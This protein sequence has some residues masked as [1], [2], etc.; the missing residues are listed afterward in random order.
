MFYQIIAA[1]V[2]CTLLLFS[3]PGLAVR[4]EIPLTVQ[5]TQLLGVNAEARFFVTLDA[6]KDRAT[7]PTLIISWARSRLVDPRRSTVSVVI[8]GRVRQSVWLADLAQAEYTVPLTGLAGGSHVVSI[9]SSMWVDED[10]CLQR[11]RNDAWF[12]IKPSSRISWERRVSASTRMAVNSIPESWLRLA[13]GKTGIFLDHQAALDKE[14]IGAYLDADQLLRYWGYQPEKTKTDRTVGQLRLVTLDRLD[15]KHEAAL[16]LL[17]NPDL[18]FVLAVDSNGVLNI[19]ARDSASLREGLLLLADDQAR[20][21]C[22][23]SLC[24]SGA[25]LPKAPFSLGVTSSVNENN[26]S[27]VWKLGTSGYPNGWQ[28]RGGGQ[29]ELRFV[30]Q[31]PA[32]WQVRESPML[33]LHANVSGSVALDQQQSAITVRINERPV[34]TYS[35]A[36]WRS[37][38][39]Q[40]RIPRDLWEAKE[41]VFEVVASLRPADAKACSLSEQDTAWIT[42]SP[43]TSLIVPYQEQAFEGVASF[44]D[45][46]KKSALPGL[47]IENPSVD[48]L[49]LVATILYPFVEFKPYKS[50]IAQRQWKVVDEQACASQHCIQV[51]SLPPADSPL[52]LSKGQWKNAKGELHVPYISLQDTA[53]LFYLPKLKEQPSQ[54]VIVPGE[55]SSV[56]SIIDPPNYVGLIGRIALFAQRWHVLDI[57]LKGQQGG[58]ALLQ[59]SNS[60]AN[61]DKN[62]SKEQASV[63]W[64]NF[65][66]AGLSVLIVA[67]VIIRLWRR[68]ASKKPD[69]NW[70]TH[71]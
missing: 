21:L 25:Q 58:E 34:A 6:V 20:A 42:I 59:E 9:R 37:E 43:E 15:K 65:L 5:E 12:T 60:E 61:K 10:P 66:W 16:P 13:D 69:E 19:V 45:E 22:T 27:Q 35:L 3:P 26:P 33:L 54:L 55:T 44:F 38:Q 31:R 23:D 28:A 71:P 68:P 57:R 7:E 63:R 62:I 29:H 48:Q 67:A 11:Y 17:E 39:A 64:L 30:W 4:V 32:T 1:V 41:W 50:A 53:G 2:F 24:L 70:E 56:D 36:Q 40:I 18:R 46:V 52:K 8:D 49:A 14:G 51:K 47:T